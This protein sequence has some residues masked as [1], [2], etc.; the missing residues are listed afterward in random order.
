MTELLDPVIKEAFLGVAEIRQVFSLT[1]GAVAGCLVNEGKVI[2]DAQARLLRSGEVIARGRVIT[3]KRFKEDATEVKSGYECG[4]RLEGNDNYR[5]RDRIECFTL[6]Q[7][8]P[9]L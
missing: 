5:E 4:V 8:K 3:L 9:S 6:E 7:V 1:K 2:R